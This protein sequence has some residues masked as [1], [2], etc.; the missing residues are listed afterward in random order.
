MLF[1][2]GRAEARAILTGIPAKSQGSYSNH[3]RRLRK[4]PADSNVRWVCYRPQAIGAGAGL[5]VCGPHQPICCSHQPLTGF[6]R[7]LYQEGY[8]NA[9]LPRMGRRIHWSQD[10][11]VSEVFGLPF[12]GLRGTWTASDF[13][14]QAAEVGHRDTQQFAGVENIEVEAPH[15]LDGSVEVAMLHGPLV[16]GHTH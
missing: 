2:L 1:S 4:D 11:P 10:P 16:M 9:A 7:S 6:N 13:Y 14:L 3:L 5:T 8:G 15:L 12:D